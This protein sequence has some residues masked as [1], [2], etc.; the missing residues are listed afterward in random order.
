MTAIRP[1]LPPTAVTL[2]APMLRP[3]GLTYVVVTRD[4]GI[5]GAFSSYARAVY[6]CNM[7]GLSIWDTLPEIPRMLV[8]W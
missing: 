8:S 5:A 6:S 2:A 7:Q 1:V 4:G 3:T